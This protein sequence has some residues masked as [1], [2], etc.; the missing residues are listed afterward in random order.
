[1]AYENVLEFF[2]E[3]AGAMDG[4]LFFTLLFHSTYNSYQ[5][6][7]YI[8]KSLKED[9]INLRKAQK[10]DLNEKESKEV[11]HVALEVLESNI[12]LEKHMENM[13]FIEI[14]K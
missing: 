4:I 8:K 11:E 13:M 14:L 5:R 1:M 10:P 7:N 12:A 9:Y 2:A 6:N 3:L